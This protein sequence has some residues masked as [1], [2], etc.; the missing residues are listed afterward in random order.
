MLKIFKTL[1]ALELSERLYEWEMA[2]G[3]GNS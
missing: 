2:W 1:S 3:V